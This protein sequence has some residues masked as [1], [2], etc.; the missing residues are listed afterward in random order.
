MVDLD[1]NIIVEAEYDFVTTFGD[2]AYRVKK[3]DIIFIPKN[4]WHKITAVGDKPAV[5]LAVSR[6]DVKHSY[7][8]SEEN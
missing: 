8:T 7:D 5:R 1:G 2:N 4:S 3:D 6:E